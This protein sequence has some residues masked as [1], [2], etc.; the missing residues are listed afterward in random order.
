MDAGT[1]RVASVAPAN[2]FEPVA[3]P[4]EFVMNLLMVVFVVSVALMVAL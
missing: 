2:R 1:H 4:S 3:E